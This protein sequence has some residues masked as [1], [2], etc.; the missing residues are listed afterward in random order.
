MTSRRPSKLAVDS[1]VDIASDSERGTSCIS[2]R[3]FDVTC[4]TCLEDR[5][6]LSA[7]AIPI[8][9]VQTMRQDERCNQ[10]Q[11][12]NNQ[13]MEDRERKMY[14]KHFDED[15]NIRSTSP[16]CYVIKLAPGL[17]TCEACRRIG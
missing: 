9:T 1:H 2:G 12:L 3:S 10:K 5:R 15:V 7:R 17:L 11:K 8:T 13:A 14:V 4:H 6:T 16:K